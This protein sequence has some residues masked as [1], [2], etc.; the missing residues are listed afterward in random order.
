M[1]ATV[2]VKLVF[3]DVHGP[4][5]DPIKVELVLLVGDFL[6]KKKV[7]DEIIIDGDLLDFYNIHSHGPKHS[8]I[9]T[10]LEEELQWGTDF[11]EALRKRFPG[12]KIT[13]IFGN[14]EDRLDRFIQENCKAFHNIL[15][16]ENQLRLKEN[17]IDFLPYNSAYRV[18]ETNLFIQ[19]S[20]PSYGVNG[21]RTSLLTKHDRSYIYACTHRKQMASITT[22]SGKVHYCY[23]NGWLGSTTLTEEH[24]R[25]F[26]YTKGHESWQ[27]A[28]SLVDVV[29][30]VEFQ[31]TQ[32][33]FLGD[34]VCV[35]GKVFT[36]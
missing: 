21:A 9:I 13:F 6:F 30:G 27:G 31:V 10:T 26:S 32:Y 36:I 16:L 20:P 7:L 24:R 29:N 28:F 23:Y 11:I 12:I 17:D 1:S 4:W 14:H 25:V 3:N 19:H 22:A 34:S 18:A 33:G 8:Q 5:H 2:K 35:A 15:R